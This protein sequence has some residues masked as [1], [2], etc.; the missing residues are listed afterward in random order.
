MQFDAQFNDHMA[1][2][3]RVDPQLVS[4]YQQMVEL[5]GMVAVTGW[6]LDYILSLPLQTA[7]RITAVLWQLKQPKMKRQG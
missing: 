2:F 5:A 6:T 3:L 1:A 7:R 4:E